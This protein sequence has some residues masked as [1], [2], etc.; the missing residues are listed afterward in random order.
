MKTKFV[1]NLL[2]LCGLVFSSQSILAAEDD[3]DQDEP[4]I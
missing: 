2:L 1:I 3:E 4:D